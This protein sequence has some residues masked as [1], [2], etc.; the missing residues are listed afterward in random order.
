MWSRSRLQRHRA[1]DEELD[2][3][4]KRMYKA[5]SGSR[6]VESR[7]GGGDVDGD[8][9]SG[10][11]GD[12]VP[13]KRPSEFVALSRRRGDDA[14]DMGDDVEMHGKSR[15]GDRHDRRDR[16]RHRHSG[17]GSDS[18][19]DALGLEKQ[20]VKEMKYLR[21]LKKLKKKIDAKS[22]DASS[23][24]DSDSDSG[25]RHRRHKDKK[26]MKKLLRKLERG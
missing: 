21:K 26:R 24:S 2:R 5:G 18:D 23:G 15:G 11:D 16:H 17:H 10:D 19:S 6:L 9:M 25:G 3:M 8:A 14:D 13:H 7:G 22:L 12:A 4:Y 1:N 20:K